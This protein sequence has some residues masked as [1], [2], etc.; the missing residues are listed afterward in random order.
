M[1]SRLRRA[2]R[3]RRRALSPREQRLAAA[4]L[5]KLVSRSRSFL[6]ARHIAAYLANDGELDPAELV[7]MAWRLGK[8]VYLPVL[9][10]DRSLRFALYRPGTILRRNPLGIPEPV[11]TR[12]LPPSR[13]DCVFMP[14]V[15][16]DTQGNRLGM[17]GGFY[18]RTF[19]FLHRRH[20]WGRPL[21]IGL[22]HGC[23]QSPEVPA[24]SWDVAMAAIATDRG[25]V[26]TG[27]TTEQTRRIV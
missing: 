16:F 15:A 18:D 5:A 3:Q 14:L 11:N 9:R 25:F 1:R 22:A 19:A 23:Q 21:L 10:R 24:E 13:M 20:R 8:R 26:A 7:A 17:G 2:M 4:R 27:Q 12:L 6:R